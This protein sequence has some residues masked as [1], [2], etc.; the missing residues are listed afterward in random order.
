MNDKLAIIK[1][2]ED[3]LSKSPGLDSIATLFKSL[4]SLSIVGSPISVLL[5]DFIPSR[6][7]LRLETFV[8]ELSV[9]Y[10]RVEEKIDIEYIKTDEFAFLFE[11]CF[12]AVSEN[13]QKEKI[14][15][16]KAILVNA[17]TDKSLI[18]L[19]KEFFLNLTKQLSVIHIQVLTFLHDT[20]GYLKM[21]KISDNQIQGRYKD[22]LPIIF[23]EIDFDT[24][25][26]VLND[27]NN[28]GLTE[29]QGSSL[30]AMTVSTGLQLL[31]DR[32]TTS[33]GEKYIRFINL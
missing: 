3:S 14:N 10:K 28:D 19:E 1:K 5:S 18:H 20:R 32:K 25:K 17:T 11:Q 12:K 22:F 26:I 15:A 13:Y 16:F 23:P 29:L 2:I 6:R 24:F 33:F 9:E 4:I 30:G 21:K 7:F 27:L 31:G 8:E